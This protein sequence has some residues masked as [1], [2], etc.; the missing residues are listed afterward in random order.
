MT[1]AIVVQTGEKLVS[2]GIIALLSAAA[3]YK[4]KTTVKSGPVGPINP[5]GPVTP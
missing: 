2:V 3:R 4:S 1:G 5:V